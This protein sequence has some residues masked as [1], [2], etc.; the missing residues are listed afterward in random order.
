MLYFVFVVKLLVYSVNICWISFLYPWEKYSKLIE[1]RQFIMNFDRNQK[2]RDSKLEMI[3]IIIDPIR[4][5]SQLIYWNSSEMIFFAFDWAKG[6]N[7]E[8][9]T[10]FFP[11]QHVGPSTPKAFLFSE[12]AWFNLLLIQ[13]SKFSHFRIIWWEINSSKIGTEY[14]FRN[15]WL[16]FFLG[17]NIVCWEICWIF[18]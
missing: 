9:K 1:R 6:S 8:D 3:D 2:N 13:L 4:R 14:Y 17:F 7:R 5:I 18:I 16:N 10:F 12:E 15:S 11:I